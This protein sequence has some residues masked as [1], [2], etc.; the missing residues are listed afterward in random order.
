MFTSH[1]TRTDRTAPSYIG[2]NQNVH[3]K[4]FNLHAELR[5]NFI[6]VNLLTAPDSAAFTRSRVDRN[7]LPRTGE[8][9]R[10]EKV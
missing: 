9:S 6:A 5:Y 4:S 1:A 8:L 7:T 3:G 10:Q 2:L